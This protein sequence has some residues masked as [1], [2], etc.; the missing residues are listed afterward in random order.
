M[1][2]VRRSW[3]KP[4]IRAR[5]IAIDYPRLS[6]EEHYYNKP[7]V[8]AL[9]LDSGLVQSTTET[10]ALQRRFPSDKTICA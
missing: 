8:A 6:E 4:R 2:S 10:L 3:L 5:K 1:L 9:L 7:S